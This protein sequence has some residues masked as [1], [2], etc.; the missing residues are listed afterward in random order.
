MAVGLEL[1]SHAAAAAGAEGGGLSDGG[2]PG[3]VGGREPR[4]PRGAVERLVKLV[5]RQAVGHK[6]DWFDPDVLNRMA[7]K[8]GTVDALMMNPAFR[9]MAQAPDAGMRD[10]EN[11]LRRVVRDVRTLKERVTD[12]P[13]P[14]QRNP[15][16]DHAMLAGKALLGY[17]CMACD[18]PLERLDEKPGPYIPTYQMPVKVP[19][20][21]D[22]SSKVAQR[23]LSPETSTVSQGKLVKK[24]FDPSHRGPQNWYEDNNGPPADALPPSDVGPKLPPGGWRGNIT[25]VNPKGVP[26][27]PDIAGVLNKPRSPAGS[28]RPIASISGVAEELPSPHS[29]MLPTL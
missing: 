5:G 15:E 8:L 29:R 24:P 13:V 7:Q 17:R 19:A 2:P 12:L 16:S 1:P 9:S 28:G 10:L 22:T 11:Q 18:R 14:G 27:L 20:A 23:G 21:P 3:L 25:E 26:A 4:T 6:M